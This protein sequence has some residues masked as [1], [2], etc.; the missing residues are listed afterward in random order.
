MQQTVS[1]SNSLQIF[2]RV[3][4]TFSRRSTRH[5]RG[6]KAFVCCLADFWIWSKIQLG[7]AS[8]CRLARKYSKA[9]VGFGPIKTFPDVNIRPEANILN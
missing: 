8:V 4:C 9:E 1:H 7:P 2:F 3:G 6:E 5:V